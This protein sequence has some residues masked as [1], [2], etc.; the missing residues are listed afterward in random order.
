MSRRRQEAHAYRAAAR[1][2]QEKKRPRMW[3]GSDRFDPD[4][5]GLGIA[6]SLI[7]L[8]LG[9]VALVLGTGNLRA[10]NDADSLPQLRM[11]VSSCESVTPPPSSRNRQPEITCFGR[12]TDGP[13]GVTTEQWHLDEAPDVLRS[14]QVVNV[15]CTPGGSCRTDLDDWGLPGVF[16]ITLG[17]LLLSAGLY[18][19]SRVLTHRYAP[20]HDD[21]F[22]RR[23]TV[24]ATLVFFATVLVL[25]IVADVL[26]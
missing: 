14:G 6:I 20:W 1:R 22:R 24:V 3:N 11:T 13:S 5:P 16:Q 23:S 19:G 18:T 21:F 15:R 8:G 10:M 7:G 25:G 2:E 26:V 17:V 9:T 4:R 12:G